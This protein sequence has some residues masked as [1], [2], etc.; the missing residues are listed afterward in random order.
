MKDMD[1][2]PVLSLF[3]QVKHFIGLKLILDEDAIKNGLG[4]QVD[5]V[6]FVR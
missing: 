3:K 1:E 4:N 5:K 2:T 6:D